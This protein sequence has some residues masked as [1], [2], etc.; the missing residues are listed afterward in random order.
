V[1][2]ASTIRKW[3]GMYIETV[4]KLHAGGKFSGFIN[5]HLKRAR[6]GKVP[7]AEEARDRERPG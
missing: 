4:T 1:R 7:R 5:N 2:S 6:G 3:L